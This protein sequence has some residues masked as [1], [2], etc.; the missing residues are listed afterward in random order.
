MICATI[1]SFTGRQGEVYELLQNLSHAARNFCKDQKGLKGFILPELE[2]TKYMSEYA[3]DVQ[4]YV[5]K[6]RYFG[7]LKKGHLKLTYYNQEGDYTGEI[8]GNGNACGYG[9]L[10]FPNGDTY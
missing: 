3:I 10:V 5:D 8:D 4:R 2:H 6:L 7:K 9:K 1:L